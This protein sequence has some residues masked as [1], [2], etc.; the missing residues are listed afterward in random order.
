V[1]FPR[2]IVGVVVSS[3]AA[4]PG[5]RVGA[6]VGSSLTATGC[7]EKGNCTG[8]V[9]PDALPDGRVGSLYFFQLSVEVTGAT[10]FGPDDFDE[11]EPGKGGLPPWMKLSK[12]GALD[13][14]P[15]QAGTYSFEA[16]GHYRY[17]GGEDAIRAPTKRRY[18]LTILPR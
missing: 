11:I 8:R 2:T 15:L 4:T 13:G 12:D 1:R 3:L 17:D 9:M 16:T 6:L 7:G 5:V 14:I 10:C 18:D